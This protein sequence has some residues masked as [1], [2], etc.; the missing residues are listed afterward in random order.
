MFKDESLDWVYLDACHL[1][2]CVVQDIAAWWPKGFIDIL[3]RT[4]EQGTETDNGFVTVYARQFG[5]LYDHFIIDVSAGGRQPVPL[6][7]GNDGN[8][9]DGHRQMVLT[10]AAGAFAVGDII[11]DE[12][13]TGAPTFTH[14]IISSD[15]LGM[16]TSKSIT[17]NS[18]DALTGDADV[19]CIRPKVSAT[20]LQVNAY[21]R[22]RY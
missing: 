13:G 3:V 12:A 21:L 8:N 17:W 11:E 22:R 5:A 1:R 6:S 2:E 16:A 15:D 20:A 4:T 18:I 10:T 7:T 9:V 14:G 19:G